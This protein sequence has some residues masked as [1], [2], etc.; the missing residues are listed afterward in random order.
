LE[1]R[2]VPTLFPAAITVPTGGSG[3]F[4]VAVVDFNGDGRPDIAVSNYS[5]GTVSVG[6]G[7]GDGTFAPALG[8]PFA[9]GASAGAVAAADFNNDG[10]QDIAVA[11]PADNRVMFFFGTGF[12]GSPFSL[13]AS[14]FA[15][16]AAD[17]NHDG[18]ADLAVGLQNGDVRVIF[19]SAG[20]FTS[21][22][23]ATG[24][25]AVTAL[26]TG[27]FNNDGNGDIAAVRQASSGTTLSIYLGN[28]HGA[29]APGA[30]I[31]M[32]ATLATGMVAGH[33]QGTNRL[34]LAIANSTNNTITVLLSTGGGNFSAPTTIPVLGNPFSL[35]A[36]DF[37]GDGH[38][39]LIK[40]NNANNS[41]TPLIGNG[42]GTFVLTPSFAVGAAP[43][44]MAV[45]DFNGDGRPDLVVVNSGGNSESALLNTSPD[46][47]FSVT[48]PSSATTGTSFNVTVTADDLNGNPLTTYRGTVHFTST[49]AL[50]SLPAD[51]T[52][53]AADAG[54][55][56]FSV[57]LLSSYNR[58]IVVTD[59]SDATIRG[60]APVSV[61]NPPLSITSLSTTTA[62]EGSAAFPLAVNGSGLIPSSV[63][64]WNDTALATTFVSQT[65]LIAT[66]PASDLAEEGTANVSVSNPA[67]GGGTTGS[68]AFTVT[69]AN[70]TAT[71]TSVSTAE[72]STSSIQVAT[73]VD[74]N[75]TAPLSDFTWNG[76]VII[77][78]GDGT[79]SAGTVSQPGG[80]GTN[81]VVS[82]A[83][84][85]SEQGTFPISVTIADIGAV[86]TTANSTAAVDDAPLSISVAP[87]KI[88]PGS[89]FSGQIATFTDANNAAQ[90]S[91]FNGLG[92]A[93]INWGDGTTTPG[94]IS[95]PGGVGTPFVVNGSHTYATT[96]NHT[97]KVTIT[98]IGDSTVT[99]QALA[100]NFQRTDIT[101]R[102]ASNGQWYVGISNASNAF[103]NS[104]WAIWNPAA[105]WVNVQTGDFN[106]DGKTDII[107]RDMRSGT[108]WVGLSKGT[109]FITSL[110]TTWNPNVT[111]VDVSVGDFNHNGKSDIIG[112]VLETGQWWLA[113]STGSSFT[114]TLWATWS[115]AVTWVDVKVGDFNGDGSADIAGRVLQNGQWWVSLSGGAT[116]TTTSL[117]TTW[118]TTVTWV[119]V[120][121][122]DFSGNGSSDLAGRISQTG[123]WWVALSNGSTSFSN[124]LWGTWSPVVTWVDVQ[125]GDFN[126]DGFTDIIG[127]V[128]QTGQ[129]WVAFSNG[130]NAF[131]NI[132]WAQW[133]PSVNWVDVQ[134]GDFN[135][136]GRDDISG[137]S[138]ATGQWWTSLS[139]GTTS[140]TSLW[141]TWNSAASWADV[142]NGA[143]VHS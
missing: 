28:G 59:T 120:Q 110:W 44:G 86:T 61:T 52:F 125:I 63:V 25:G 19:G 53:T 42:D 18:F 106:G 23:V 97:I 118:S 116:A 134:V 109:G 17:F 127:R 34:D 64:T 21:S 89:G 4:G 5:S 14:P 131:S 65:Q 90:L 70:L 74:A 79:Q 36:G 87:I 142:Q 114:N 66:V 83:H 126:G 122:G 55:H 50:A 102:I 15:E 108:W 143:F 45:G 46:I 51:Y 124:A 48:A 132:L 12:G 27:D 71:G 47:H 96:D 58:T 43:K 67:P 103:S 72:G 40:S 62:V 33:F 101:G 26:V 94:T 82:G 93:S 57:T 24:T 32:T 100:S 117:W 69:D 84:A 112:R 20:A 85:Y 129:W 68:V 92:A 16:A 11:D 13:P 10:H 39:D 9:V 56:T 111:W 107:G 104:L 54:V 22:L 95:Q 3:P 1:D 115:P 29:F 121:V 2:A 60:F 41:I 141:T 78:W 133:N 128:L 99:G 38:V 35:V 37:N 31:P 49:D 6:L 80:I 138:S 123:Q 75:P 8:S 76:A 77:H 137:R 140:T 130:S 7:N 136:D 113:T 98:D 81:F 30:F 139:Q 119:D 135:A 91:D 88:T 73:F 105:T